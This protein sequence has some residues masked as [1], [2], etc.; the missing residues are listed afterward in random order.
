[1]GAKR[2]SVGARDRY[3]GVIFAL[4]RA[5]GVATGTYEDAVFAIVGQEET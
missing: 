5:C 3:A 1:M 4:E 2:S